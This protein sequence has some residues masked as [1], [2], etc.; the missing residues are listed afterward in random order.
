M[1]VYCHLSRISL[2]DAA[3]TYNFLSITED[4]CSDFLRCYLRGWLQRF[5]RFNKTSV[6]R[7]CHH[8]GLWVLCQN[9]H[10]SLKKRS[11]SASV[12]PVIDRL[13]IK[14][15]SIALFNCICNLLV[16]ISI[17]I[18]FSNNFMMAT[19]TSYPEYEHTGIL[20]GSFQ[21]LRSTFDKLCS[22]VK[23]PFFGEE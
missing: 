19:G 8:V 15:I 12:L 10:L 14:I 2:S 13:P 21:V 5:N 18:I 17:C 6:T 9:Q 4:T 7:H 16:G 1:G 22:S 11:F 3:D 23:D 20:G